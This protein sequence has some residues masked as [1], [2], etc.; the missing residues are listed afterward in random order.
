MQ[1]LSTAS[2]TIANKML[3]ESY[4]KESF[5]SVGERIKSI[6]EGKVK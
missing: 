1:K 5:G 2:T 6:L 3:G 4:K